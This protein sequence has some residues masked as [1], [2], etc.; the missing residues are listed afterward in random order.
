M[1]GVF[2]IGSTRMTKIGFLPLSSPKASKMVLNPK[3]TR[4]TLCFLILV[5]SSSLSLP[6]QILIFPVYPQNGVSV[7]ELPSL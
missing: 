4:T 6:P 1:Y 2:S 3:K 5:E 7:I